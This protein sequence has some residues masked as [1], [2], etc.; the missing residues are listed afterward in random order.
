MNMPIRGRLVLLNPLLNRSS[1]VNWTSFERPPLVLVGEYPDK[2]GEIYALP[3]H[4]DALG[5]VYRADLFGDPGESSAF[6]QTYGYPLGLPGTYEEIS[7]L[8]G[9]FSRNKSGLFGIG[10]AGMSGPDRA[11]SP[12]ISILSSYGSGIVS[13]S[14]GYASGTWNS[15]EAVSA[16]LMLKNL[17]GKQPPGAAFWGDAEVADAFSSG[18][19]AMA[20]TW[21]SRFNSINTAAKAHNI[22]VAFIPLPGEITERGSFRGISVRMD[23]IS[24]IQGGSQENGQKFL[25]WFY[26]PEVQMRYAESG[27]QPSLMQV[28]DTNAYLSMNGYNRAFP[29]SMR[30]GVSQDKGE[31]AGDIMHTCEESVSAVLALNAGSPG[32]VKHILDASAARIDQ[33]ILP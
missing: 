15:S 16:L 25:T 1:T 28:Q 27:Y 6:C 23:G 26:S 29:E 22:S 4:Q 24:L 12:W 7:D 21:F 30:V 3:F 8:A 9:H 5:L 18:T 32:E 11:S 17:S 31:R 10:F 19:I 2:S 33:G 20:I 13:R 14:S